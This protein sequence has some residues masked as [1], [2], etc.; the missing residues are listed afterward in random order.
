MPKAVHVSGWFRPDDA[1]AHPEHPIVLPG[2]PVDPDY[3]IDEGAHPV[4]PIVIPPLVGIWP[5]PGHPA[6]PIVIP[7]PPPASGPVYIEG[8]PENPITSNPGTLTPALPPGT[9]PEK[10][11]AVLVTIP[12]VEGNRWLTVDMTPTVNP[13]RK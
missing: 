7:D 12:G 2:D 11:V 9:L 8:T 6:H 10:K 5:S 13:L 3:G 1:G 4:H